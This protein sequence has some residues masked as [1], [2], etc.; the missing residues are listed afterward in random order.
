MRARCR[1]SAA[2]GDQTDTGGAKSTSALL[3]L[4][5]YTWSAEGAFWVDKLIH[6]YISRS[7]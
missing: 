2:R 4:L 3:Q 1:F 7:A 6:T 5:S